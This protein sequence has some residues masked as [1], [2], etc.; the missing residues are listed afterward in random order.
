MT[1][2]SLFDSFFLLP[3]FGLMGISLFILASSAQTFLNSQI[4]FFILGFLIYIIFS[5]V[6][7]QIWRKF[8][9]LIYLSSVTVLLLIFFMPQVRGAYRWLDLGIF[10]LQPS[11]IIKPFMVIFLAQQ[12]S[13]RLRFDISTV[14]KP[15]LYFLP[16]VVLIFM[17]PDL[18]NVLVYVSIFLSM[19]ILSGLS[20]IYLVGGIVLFFVFMPLL[21]M[22]LKDYQRARLLSFFNPYLDPQGTGYNAIQAMITIGS[23]G[24][25]GLGLGRGTQSRLLFLPEYQTD[26]IFSSIVEVLGFFG[27]LVIIIL[28]LILLTKIIT[29]VFKTEDQFGQLIVIGVFTQLFIQVFINIGMNLGILPITGITMPLV[30]YGGSSIVSTFIGLGLVTSVSHLS[31][32][33]PLVIR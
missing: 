26:F 30:S 8:V 29:V 31:D 28:Y 22:L 32:S 14:I 21:W 18:G 3:I 11:E 19:L 20:W 15:V 6:N 23:G 10:I 25:W 12:L 27:G 5:S 33:K 13:H 17:Q 4:S 24:L 7:Y 1:F 16:V 9:N 2:L